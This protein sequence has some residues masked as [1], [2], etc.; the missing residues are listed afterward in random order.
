LK[1]TDLG[2][3]TLTLLPSIHELCYLNYHHAP[4]R[5]LR[6]TF[7]LTPATK[8][9]VDRSVVQPTTNFTSVI[10]STNVYVYNTFHHML[11]ITNMFP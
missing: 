6:Q 5:D 2:W 11:L 8:V 7:L 1:L 9:A 3:P 10:K 4:M